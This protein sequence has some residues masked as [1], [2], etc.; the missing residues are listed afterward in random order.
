MNDSANEAVLSFDALRRF[1][2][3]K[4]P[5]ETCDFCS[6]ALDARH[7]HILEI[8]NQK[9]RCVCDPCALR[10]ENV[11]EGRF[12][13]I[14]R[15]PVALNGF[16]MTD[17][18]WNAFALPINLAFFFNSTSAQKVVAMFPSPG[19][20]MESLLSF[21]DWGKLAAENPAIEQMQADVQ[22]LLVNR[23]GAAREY[24]IAP[25]DLCYELSG[26]VRTH[27][28]GLSGGD[29]VWTAINR[30]FSNLKRHGVHPITQGSYGR[31]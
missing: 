28:R 1:T 5:V 23:I 20:A 22:A 17:E 16:R 18:Q 11:I 6:V 12:K 4:P 2:R 19:G 27:W 30:F 3:Q 25:I 29:A 10:F 8:A 13:L 14:P 9:L 21:H 24:F 26:L 7:R 31:A 15:D